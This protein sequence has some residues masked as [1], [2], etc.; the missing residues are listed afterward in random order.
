MLLDTHFHYDFLAPEL[1]PGFCKALL[2]QD[3]QVVAQTLLPSAYLQLR[4]ATAPSGAPEGSVPWGSRE[5]KGQ[6]SNRQLANRLAPNDSGPFLSLGFH[7]WWM[8]SPEQVESELECFEAEVASTRFIGEIG[9]D[10]LPRRLA[11]SPADLQVSALR[12]IFAA[13][14]Q[15]AAGQSAEQ[16]YVMSLHAVRSASAV[17]DLFEEL[18]LTD[19]PIVPVLHRFGGTSDELTR[20]IALGGCISVHPQMLDTKRGR[21]YVKQVPASRLL[22]ETDL[23][24]EPV[25]ALDTQVFADQVRRRL[26]QLV[27]VISA[28]RGEVFLPVLLENQKRL[29]S[30][31]VS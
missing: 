13:V 7:P 21:A 24:E 2:G 9:L 6:I 1:R 5:S 30:S 8:T 12:R 20:L 3:V 10:Y 27:E 18:A 25:D 15:A 22:L 11:T 29:Y 31:V 4:D 28:E 23:P 26:Q 17:L 14:R 16:P 19:C